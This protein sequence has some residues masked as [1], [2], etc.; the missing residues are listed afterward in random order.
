MAHG[1]ID[2]TNGGVELWGGEQDGKDL[3]IRCL[4]GFGSQEIEWVL[5]VRFERQR[6]NDQITS[7]TAR[8]AASRNTRKAYRTTTRKLKKRDRGVSSLSPDASRHRARLWA[9]TV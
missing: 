7:K 3:Y 9:R 6:T 5:P 2:I 1:Q 8:G 4:A